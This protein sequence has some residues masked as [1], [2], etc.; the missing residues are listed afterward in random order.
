LTIA[1]TGRYEQALVQLGP[2]PQYNPGEHTYF[3]ARVAAI[4]GQKKEALSL[5]AQAAGEG[6]TG[7]PW[8]HS[9]GYRDL[10]ILSTETGFRELF[11][12]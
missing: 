10:S 2:R 3:R 12:Y 7:M 8:V 1:R 5:L 6:Y 9:T 4:A 11:S